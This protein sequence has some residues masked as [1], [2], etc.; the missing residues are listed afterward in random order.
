M[1]IKSLNENINNWNKKV[2]AITLYFHTY[3]ALVLTTIFYHDIKYLLI[4]LIIN[5]FYRKLTELLL[6]KSFFFH[7][8]RLEHDIFLKRF[9]LISVSSM[10]Y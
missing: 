1:K 8:L 2:M 5:F 3:K 4:L 7:I 10:I 6:V 9:G